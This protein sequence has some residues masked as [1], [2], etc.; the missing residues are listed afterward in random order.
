MREEGD[1]RRRK[2]TEG[3]GRRRKERIDAMVDSDSFCGDVVVR[4]QSLPA[5]KADAKHDAC[6][7][8]DMCEFPR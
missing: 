7:G 1:G 4:E 8:W 3:D 6:S 2:E 5:D